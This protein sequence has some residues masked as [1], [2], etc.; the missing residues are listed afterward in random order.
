MC[1]FVYYTVEYKRDSWE[2]IVV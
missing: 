1:L 2:P